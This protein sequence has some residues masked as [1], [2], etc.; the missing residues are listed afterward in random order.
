MIDLLDP[1]GRHGQAKMFGLRAEPQAPFAIS[2]CEIEVTSQDS[3]KKC[4]VGLDKGEY[5]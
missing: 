1:R 4:R 3:A 2:P 5:S